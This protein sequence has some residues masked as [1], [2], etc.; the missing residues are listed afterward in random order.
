ME[1]YLEIAGRMGL[2]PVERCATD[3]NCPDVFRLI[4]GRFAIIGS[5]ATEELRGLLPADAG[6]GPGERIVIIDAATMTNAAGDVI[7]LGY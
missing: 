5:E 7:A 6:V 4:D 2:S 3:A 1:A